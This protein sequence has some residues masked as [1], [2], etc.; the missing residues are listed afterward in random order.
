METTRQV[1]RVLVITL[2]LNLTVAFGKIGVGIISGALAITADGFHSLIDGSSNIIA[3]VAN[4]IAGQPPDDDHPY[5]HGR[6]ETLAALL[7]GVFLLFV[8]WEI[9]SGVIERLRSGSEPEITPLTLAVMFGTLLINIGVSR[10]QI[11][12]GKRLRSQL[13]LADAAN[14]RA[15]VF[16]T[17]S[18]I[19]S[20]V[21]VTFTGWVWIDALAALV[22]VGLIGQAAWR[23]LHQT[24]RVLV[25]TAPYSPQD[26]IDLMHNIPNILDITRARSRGSQEA[27]HIDVDV[28]VPPEM[29]TAQS[30]ALTDAIRQRLTENLDG[31]QEVEVH[32][33]PDLSD[34]ANYALAAR[35]AADKYGFG[36]H[37]ITVIDTEK[38]KLL[39]M[40]VEV[41]PEQTLQAAHDSV[42]RL[43]QELEATLPEIDEVI[44]HIEPVQ[45]TVIDQT[46]LSSAQ[47]QQLKET[48]LQV[49]EHHFPTVDWHHLTIYPRDNQFAL[50]LHAGFQQ[51]VTV[52]QAHS[53]AEQAETLIR[54]QIPTIIR[55]T[56][57]TEPYESD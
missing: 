38:G 31:V 11:R 25:D 20:I 34:K 15:D 41:P 23:I 56:I 1:R 19:F 14:T 6:F 49:L 51:D 52:A 24:G 53:L 12:Q 48:A 27:A 44:T 17:L 46:C 28:C 35:A 3:L 21:A 43:E 4:A 30:A 9:I 2:I 47:Q 39:E 5:G 36:T 29:T 42:T 32:F 7:I 8:A 50:T 16:I 33:V 55:V 13:L 10:Y 57:H 40:H 18:V 22:V 45:V 37:E 54:M 26:I